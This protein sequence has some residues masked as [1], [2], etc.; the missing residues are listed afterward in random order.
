MGIEIRV[1]EIITLE[2]EGDDLVRQRRIKELRDRGYTDHQII[3]MVKEE[4]CK[5]T[6]TDAA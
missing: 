6:S 3:E 1:D 2:L 5:S 4:E